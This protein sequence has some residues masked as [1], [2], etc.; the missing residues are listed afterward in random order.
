LCP[1]SQAEELQLRVDPPDRLFL[2]FQMF[3]HLMVAWGWLSLVVI[4]S[5]ETA[6]S[7]LVRKAEL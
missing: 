5:S 7:S 4:F 1:G 3:T 2:I 6:F